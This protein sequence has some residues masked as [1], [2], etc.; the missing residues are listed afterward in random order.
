M[1]FLGAKISSIPFHV[2]NVGNLSLL[3]HLLF[4]FSFS[5]SNFISLYSFPLSFYIFI[6][7]YFSLNCGFFCRYSF[8]CLVTLIIARSPRRIKD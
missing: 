4:T 1:I 5:L 6:F 7:Y 3:F 2:T 8:L